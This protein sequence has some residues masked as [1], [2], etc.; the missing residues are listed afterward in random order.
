MAV[1]LVAVGGEGGEVGGERKE[2]R[3]EGWVRAGVVVRNDFFFHSKF[4]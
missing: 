2:K 3:R 1:V 4:H